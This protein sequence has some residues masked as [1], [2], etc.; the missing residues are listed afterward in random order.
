MA[1]EINA[2]RETTATDPLDLEKVRGARVTVARNA[3]DAEDCS[4]LL[5]A[6]G[7]GKRVEI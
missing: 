4:E 5:E 1:S 2:S 6:L 3:R 7:I